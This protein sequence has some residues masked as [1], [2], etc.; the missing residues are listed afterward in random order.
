MKNISQAIFY[1]LLH[2]MWQGLLLALLTGL[3]I[4]S[5]RRRPASLR[6]N[7][8]TG[9]LFLFTALVVYTLIVELTVNESDRHQTI[10]AYIRHTNFLTPVCS[11]IH[12]HADIFVDAWLAL[13]LLK[14][15]RMMVGLYTLKRMTSV[16]TSR[17]RG[18]W[19][20]H[21][22][23]LVETMKISTPVRLLESGITKVPLVIGYLKPVI[24][25]PVGL[26]NSLEP[27]QVEAILLHELAHIVR[28]D[29]LVN[30]ILKIIGIL[31]F[32]N[33]AVL[34][35][36]YLISSERENCCDDI[37]IGQTRNRFGYMRALISFE[38]YRQDLPDQ[39][40]AISGHTATIPRRI[41]RM[42]SGKNRSLVKLEVIMLAL[43]TILFVAV[44]MLNYPFSA[45]GS[46][47]HQQQPLNRVPAQAGSAVLSCCPYMDGKQICLAC[48][49][50][51][52]CQ[53][54]SMSVPAPDLSNPTFYIY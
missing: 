18:F 19:E 38:E 3:I 14:S 54:A 48:G 11:Y 52:R 30:L 53:C 46:P 42:I 49:S 4:V 13:V 37:A 39:A 36:S 29:Y 1:T 32:F 5:T 41:E 21:F 26:I 10:D 50:N 28:K 7:L 31:F 15:G 2:S 33:P 6:Y 17:V 22:A 8:L 51:I 35:V 44:S 24:L 20:Q 9:A 47:S 23:D 43:M 27:D 34:W 25:V 16:R 40:L 12:R 45:I